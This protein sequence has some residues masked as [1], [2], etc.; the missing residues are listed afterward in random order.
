MSTNLSAITSVFELA[1]LTPYERVTLIYLRTLS[2]EHA[3]VFPSYETIA[4]KCG[5]VRR[6][7][8]N[9]IKRLVDAGLITKEHRYRIVAADRKQTSNTYEVS[10]PSSNS[11]VETDELAPSNSP[12]NSNSFKPKQEEEYINKSTHEI[13]DIPYLP[14]ENEIKRHKIT[15]ETRTAILAHMTE[16]GADIWHYSAEAIRRALKKATN[17]MRLGSGLY[18]PPKWIASAIRNEQMNLDIAGA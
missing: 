9:V 13:D 12:Y 10:A 16:A 8:I 1:D 5:M 14:F 15:S 17:R 11:P 18:N 3:S 6:T 2:L 4:Q 7:A